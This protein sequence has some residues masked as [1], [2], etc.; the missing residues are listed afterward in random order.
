M[1]WRA[2]LGLPVVPEV[3]SRM[4]NPGAAAAGVDNVVSRRSASTTPVT[5]HSIHAGSEGGI[6]ERTSISSQPACWQA[7]NT[8]RMASGLAALNAARVIACSRN[9][10]ASERAAASSSPHVTTRPGR[11]TIIRPGS[12]ARSITRSML[13]C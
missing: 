4:A 12:R 13:E 6:A 7:S 3:V 2:T 1:E 5:P 11:R 10:P 9:C 8:A